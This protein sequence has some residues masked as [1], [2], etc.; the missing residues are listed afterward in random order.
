MTLS[1]R[2]IVATTIET[3]KEDLEI[4]LIAGKSLLI[5]KID[6]QTAVIT[7]DLQDHKTEDHK[8]GVS[9]SVSKIT[10]ITTGLTED[11]S[12]ITLAAK[13]TFEIKEVLI[14]NKVAKPHKSKIKMD[15][16]KNFLLLT[17]VLNN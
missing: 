8:I 15:L 5:S 10:I 17:G 12:K 9:K 6:I 14:G 3:D 2:N 1:L 16:I 4:N 7:M 11:H 13:T